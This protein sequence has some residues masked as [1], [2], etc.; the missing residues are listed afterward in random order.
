MEEPVI[1][2]PRLPAPPPSAA[3][4]SPLYQVMARGSCPDGKL[5]VR[6]QAVLECY[7]NEDLEDYSAEKDVRVN[8]DVF[9]EIAR[10]AESGMN[11]VSGHAFSMDTT[12]DL[13]REAVRLSHGVPLLLSGEPKRA[14]GASPAYFAAIVGEKSVGFVTFKIENKVLLSYSVVV[15]SFL[16]SDSDKQIELMSQLARVFFERLLSSGL[17]TQMAAM[18]V[19]RPLTFVR[20]DSLE[21]QLLLGSYVIIDILKRGFTKT[22][23]T[24]DSFFDVI[25]SEDSIREVL[26]KALRTTQERN[27]RV[28]EQYGPQ[29]PEEVAQTEGAHLSTAAHFQSSVDALWGVPSWLFRARQK[30]SAVTEKPVLYSSLTAVEESRGMG[31]TTYVPPRCHLFSNAHLSHLV[32]CTRT[33]PNEKTEVMVGFPT[34]LPESKRFRPTNVGER[35]VI[36]EYNNGFRVSKARAGPSTT[37]IPL[38]QIPVLACAFT[39]V[40][41]DG[42]FEA[43]NSLMY[44]F[45]RMQSS[46]VEV[47]VSPSAERKPGQATMPLW[48]TIISSIS[49]AKTRH[50]A[51]S[52]KA[53]PAP[54]R[55]TIMPVEDLMFTNNEF[56]KWKKAFL[57]MPQPIRMINECHLNA[58]N[59]REQLIF[60]QRCLQIDILLIQTSG[61]VRFNAFTEERAGSRFVWTMVVR[62][63]TERSSEPWKFMTKN[64]KIALL[65]PDEAEAVVFRWEQAE[66]ATCDDHPL[67]FIQSVGCMI[68]SKYFDFDPAW[69]QSSG[70]IFLRSFSIARQHRIGEW[71]KWREES[72]H[73]IRSHVDAMPKRF[74]GWFSEK[75]AGGDLAP[76]FMDVEMHARTCDAG[77]AVI[78]APHGTD[79]EVVSGESGTTWLGRADQWLVGWR[80]HEARRTVGINVVFSSAVHPRDAGNF[81]FSCHA[82]PSVLDRI[83]QG[84]TKFSEQ[85]TFEQFHPATLGEG[86]ADEVTNVHFME[87]VYER[88]EAR[89][90]EVNLLYQ[91]GV[92]QDYLAEPSNYC[93]LIPYGREKAHEI[94]FT[95]YKNT[96]RILL[97]D[98]HDELV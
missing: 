89:K 31:P 61:P 49:A 34:K 50:A 33:L 67:T 38:A 6:G 43:E 39:V 20:A 98:A 60:T 46:C 35:C 72:A 9:D 30:R 26:R 7:L 59:L 36:P 48:R 14:K 94:V 96:F 4:T 51:R 41:K 64:K 93:F 1:K 12:P 74:A 97:W 8:Q 88:G 69:E 65:T 81:S 70:E 2:R 42:K 16:M 58:L 57:P 83:R 47:L 19:E 5:F 53:P 18:V 78:L 73:A 95:A 76:L 44:N 75:A 55:G 3:P 82:L 68:M 85:L 87:S 52:P 10:A 84:P 62:R 54:F 13:V 25:E 92:M 28:L 71:K 32:I 91:D 21:N 22:Y 15:F 29:N 77:H 17:V 80:F 63:N 45:S 11:I 66:W 90:H 56:E 23:A 86:S 40:D 37:T 24:K 79:V 27:A